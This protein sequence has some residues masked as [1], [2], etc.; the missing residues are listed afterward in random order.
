MARRYLLP[1]YEGQF[2]VILPSGKDAFIDFAYPLAMLAIEVDGRITHSKLLDREADYERQ[3]ELVAAGW[4]IL[5]FTSRQI[6][7]RPDWVADQILAALETCGL[8]PGK[9]A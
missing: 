1:T 7:R 3:A 9:R 5:R 8:G 6:R 4:R 2:H